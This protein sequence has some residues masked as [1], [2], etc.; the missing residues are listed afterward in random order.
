MTT[1]DL[2][3]T[4]ST[5]RAQQFNPKTRKLELNEIPIPSPGPDELLVKVLCASLCHSDLMPFEDNDK[6]QVSADAR[7]ITIGHE[8]SGVVVE[9]GANGAADFEPG[10]EVGFLP[11]KDSCFECRPCKTVHNLWCDKGEVKMQGFAYDG[12]F[13]EYVIVDRQNTMVLPPQLRAADAAPLF[14]AGVTAFNG[15]DAIKLPRDSWVAIIGT[16][17]LGHLGV[18]YAKAMGYKVIGLD[19]TDGAV[20]TAKAA[21]AD[22]AF[23][24]VKDSAT[25]VDEVKRIT[26][27]GVAAAVNFTASKRAYLG[28]PDLVK[29]PGIIVAVGIPNESVEFSIFDIA[30]GRF[31]LRGANNGTCYSMPK[32]IN[33]SAEHNIR[34]HTEWFKLEDVGAM[35][36]KMQQH[37]ATG[38]MAVRF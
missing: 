10:Q 20:A 24:S 27:G 1:D 28:M 18:Q 38:R 26:G 29:A 30:L 12:Y 32:C 31:Q 36:E 3:P 13:Q 14:C 4:K 9:V 33:F 21:G 16:G 7:P 23:N 19:I 2:K 15:I 37:K 11:A 5:M 6:I 34:P 25:Y 22:H 8:G 17:G 35:V